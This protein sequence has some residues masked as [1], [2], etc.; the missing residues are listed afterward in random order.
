M[1]ATVLKVGHHG[2]KTS[3]SP[4]FLEAVKPTYAVI[5]CGQDNE[6]GYPHPESIENLNK[7]G[8]NILRTD[9]LGT[10]VIETD[11]EKLGIN[12]VLSP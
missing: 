8:T 7:A 6:Y 1:K 12:K 9:V 11:G 10:L 4:D 3:S 5:S 2:S